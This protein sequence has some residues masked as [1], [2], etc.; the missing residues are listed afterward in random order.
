MNKLS[1]TASALA[2]A[3]AFAAALG[4]ANVATSTD[5]A[6]AGETEKCYGVA[7]AGKNDCKAGEGTTCQGSS[8]VDY[9]GNAWS[10][11]AKGT[12]VTMSRGNSELKGSLAAVPNLNS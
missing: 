4:A 10:K 8:K 11:V 1:K 9:Q 5:A 3:G 7:L 6:A 2:V 12:C